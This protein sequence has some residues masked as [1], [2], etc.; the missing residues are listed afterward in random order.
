PRTRGLCVSP[1]HFVGSFGTVFPVVAAGGLLVIPSRETLAMPR[2]FFRAVEK[3]KI[4]HTSFSPTYLRLLLA[5]REICRL[6]TGPLVTMSLGGE[7]LTMADVRAVSSA[8]P[9]LRLINRYGQTETTIAVTTYDIE[10]EQ[11]QESTGVPI[12]PP[13]PGVSFFLVREDGSLVDTA[14]EVAELY[15][16][17]RQLMIGYWRDHVMTDAALRRDVV[18]GKVLY[19]TGDLAY[20]DAQGIYFVIGRTDRLV[21]R[22]GIRIS[23]DEIAAALRSIDTVNSVACI[24]Y[25][26]HGQLAIAAFVTMSTSSSPERL[27]HRAA[28]LLPTTMLPDRLEIV[29]S[30]PMTA[31]S[32]LDERELLRHAELRPIARRAD[33]PIENRNLE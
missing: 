9:S 25:D 8:A 2:M 10:P 23:T 20:R 33:V 15:V 22:S 19:K 31:G 13:N 3:Y 1:V 32:K 6:A 5:S 28:Q 17:G 27:R 7:A 21:K 26:D 12:G 16:G 30:L 18:E 29:E 14:E 4:T 24:P 11:L